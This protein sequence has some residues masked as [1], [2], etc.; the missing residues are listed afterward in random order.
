MAPTALALAPLAATTIDRHRQQK[1]PALAGPFFAPFISSLS[2][3]SY[4]QVA[5]AAPRRSAV[6]LEG[7][8]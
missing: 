5:S 3:Y 1:G 7:G 4:K 2:D 8:A 6:W